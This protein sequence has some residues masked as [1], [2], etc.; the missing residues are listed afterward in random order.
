MDVDAPDMRRSIEFS[1]S[2]HLARSCR[3]GAPEI[4][5]RT[6][7]FFN[8]SQM[9]HHASSTFV[10]AM[11]KLRIQRPELFASYPAFKDILFVDKYEKTQSSSHASLIFKGEPVMDGVH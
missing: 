9:I 6:D 5:R 10:A 7:L 3:D 2:V 1:L 4:Q 8:T 11:S